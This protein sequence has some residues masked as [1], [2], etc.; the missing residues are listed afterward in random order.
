MA[1]QE[2]YYTLTPSAPSVAKG[3]LC[4]VVG[5]KGQSTGRKPFPIN[6]ITNPNFDFWDKKAKRFKSGTDTAKVNNPILDR[7]CD[8]CDKLL[9]NPK[10][11][12]PQQFIDAL[13]LGAAPD[14]VLTLGGFLSQIIDEMRNGK[15]NKRPSR[16]YQTYVN[17]LHKLEREGDL[18][19]IPIGDI[20]NRHFI[21]FG[22]FVLSLADNEGRSNYYNL[23]K[24]FKQVHKKAFERELNDNSLRFRY[25]D[26][27][28]LTD[29]VEKLCPL[30]LEQY[31]QFCELDLSKIPQ[32][33][34]KAD[35][36]K[37]LYHDVCMF[38]YELKTR[39][40]DCIRA[41]TD[42]IITENGKTYLRY[43]AEKKKNS[44]S[45][46]KVTKAELSEKALQIIAKYKGKSSKGYIFPFALN[47]HD[48]DYTNAKSWNNW[49]NRKNRA[50][51]MIRVWLKK[52][53]RVLGLEFDLTLYTF[54]RSA[55]T[56]ACMCDS[57]NL[58]RI[59]LN[60]GTSVN[61][62]QKHYVSNVG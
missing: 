42:N 4:V 48:W 52:V 54:R 31:R 10:I 5:Y 13:K 45:R 43:V 22:N 59:A 28:P 12:T 14:D 44:K 7:V 36:Y 16:A 29:D 25:A 56:H 18:I 32:S 21:Q 20:A 61:M 53:Q 15:N 37:E 57:P 24:L 3:V 2:I 60:G 62:L 55:L 50:L 6:G 19:N 41:H 27:A 23:M 1:N 39:P 46:D 35:F 47:E 9:A 11:T 30:T 51:E 38:L 17:L 33:G 34:D 49:N 26:S 8:L 40:V 58:M